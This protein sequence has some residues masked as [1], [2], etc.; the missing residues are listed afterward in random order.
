MSEKT[1]AASLDITAAI[2]GLEQAADSIVAAAYGRV[3]AL[4]RVPADMAELQTSF[5]NASISPFL[6]ALEVILVIALVRTVFLLADLWDAKISPKKN[7]WRTFFTRIVATV[8]ALA[9]GFAAARLLVG[10]G[11]PLRTLRLWAIATVASYLIVSLT[12]FILLAS[13][14]YAFRH[15]SYHLLALVRDLSVPIT[16]ALFGLAFVETLQIWNGGSGLLDLT[17]TVLVAIPAYLLFALALWR[18]RRALASVVAGPRPR[19]HWRSHLARRWPAVI[20]GFLVITFISTQAAL[21]LGAPLPGSAVVLTVLMLLLTPHLDAMILHWAQRKLEAPTASIA[22]AAGRQTTRFAVL[23]VTFSLLGSLW[24][25]PLA[26]ALG[27]ELRNVAR[28]AFGMALI[29]LAAAFMWNAVGTLT[30]RTLRGRR[31]T[32][33]GGEDGGLEEPRSRLGTT[34]AGCRLRS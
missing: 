23:I 6:L 17:R 20:I 30:A 7:L 18:N 8:L 12:G 5:A 28:E 9:V 33:G 25:T 29:A 15:R 19:S 26:L 1:S 16:W 13:R 31:V 4:S 14:R 2:D 10:T 34:R 32:P 3:S 24:A 27:L 21:T 11:V 22:A